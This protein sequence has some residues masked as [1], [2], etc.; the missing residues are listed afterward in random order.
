MSPVSRGSRLLESRRMGSSPRR[1]RF[2]L[3]TNWISWAGA[4]T[5]LGHLAV[6]LR[7]AGHS[8]TLLATGRVVIDPAALEAAGVEV[9]GLDVRRRWEKLLVP[10]RVARYARR[11]DLVHCTGWDAT[12]WGRLGALLARRPMVITEHTPG[13][14]YQVSPTG[15]SRHRLI[16]LH[17]R[18]LARFTYAAVVVGEWQRELLEREGMSGEAI[19]HIP[20]AVPIAELREQARNGDGRQ[21]LGI[22]EDALVLIEVA[23]F[24]P[25]KGQASV[26]RVAAEL[27]EALG[28]VRVLFVGSG[29]TEEEVRREAERLDAGWASFL[30]HRDD[31]PALLGLADV[32]VLPSDGEGLPMSLLESIAIGTPVVGTDVGDV[33]WLIETTGAGICVAAGD[34]AAFGEACRGLLADPA[35][36]ERLRE[37]GARGVERFDAPQMVERYERVFE[38]A[39]D[40][41]PIPSL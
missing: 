22:P 39:V 38:A 15:A 41:A 12:L 16:A 1:L 5:Q 29:E 27:R 3:V 34:E 23:R 36:R 8:V 31:V 35:L 9:V 17:N 7:E 40:S 14:E 28:E 33:R 32:S 10:F 18:L 2:L 25:Q 21:A 11:S 26:L 4:E 24:A 13:R 20:N 37:A 30:G 6:G 19:V